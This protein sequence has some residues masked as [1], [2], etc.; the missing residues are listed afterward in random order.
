M[1]ICRTDRNQAEIVD[2][3]RKVGCAVAHTH[4]VGNGFPDIVVSRDGKTYLLEIKDG[5]KPPSRR[6]LTPDEQRFHIEWRAPVHIVYSIDDAIKV[7]LEK[8]RVE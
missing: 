5:T 3:L 8:A 7:V 6:G 4:M 2:A 1:R